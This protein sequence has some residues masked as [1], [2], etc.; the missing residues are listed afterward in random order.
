MSSTG[1]ASFA[2]LHQLLEKKAFL[3]LHG[4]LVS[5]DHFA[6]IW[7]RN[8]AEIDVLKLRRHLLDLI[9]VMELH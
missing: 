9:A 4:H 7:R 2:N 1:A 3:E 5:V 6:K 8:A